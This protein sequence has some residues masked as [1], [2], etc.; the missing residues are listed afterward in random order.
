MRSSAI[1]RKVTGLSDQLPAQDLN[2]ILQSYDDAKQVSLWARDS[3]A[4]VLQAGIITG[5]SSSQ[6]APQAFITRAEVALIIQR[7]LQQS[8]LI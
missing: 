2:K 6:L 5:R 8:E 7:L 4:D 3:V 1:L